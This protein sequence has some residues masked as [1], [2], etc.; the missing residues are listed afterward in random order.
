NC[1]LCGKARDLLNQRGVPFTETVVTEKN[2]TELLD[3]VGAN[4]VPSIVV[5]SA[6]QQGFEETAYHGILDVAGYP[7]LGVLPPRAQKEPAAGGPKP[8]AAPDEAPR[9]GPYAPG[10]RRSPQK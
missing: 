6:V 1:E 10:G 5:G 8:E 7:K 9:G 3:A 2:V 4:A